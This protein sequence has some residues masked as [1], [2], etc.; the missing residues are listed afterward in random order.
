[1]A[2]RVS[3]VL[4][5]VLCA[6]L[7]L[8]GILAPASAASRN[9]IIGLPQVWS[10]SP[11]PV[12]SLVNRLVFGSEAQGG[13]RPGDSLRVKEAPTQRTVFD[14]EIPNDPAYEVPKFRIRR[15]QAKIERFK[16]DV[17]QRA[18]ASA[19]SAQ[20]GSQLLLPQF[21]TEISKTVLPT[22]SDGRADI[23]LFGSALFDDPRREGFSMR[24][25]AWPSDG[26][27]LADSLKSP[28]STLGKRLDGAR[29]SFCTSETAAD[30]LSDVQRERVERMWT[31]FLSEQGAQLTNFS[32][33]TIPCLENF[34]QGR[35]DATRSFAINRAEQPIM[36]RFKPKGPPPPIDPNPPPV[37]PPPAPRTSD[38]PS[39]LQPNVPLATAAP[40]SLKGPLKLGIRWPCAQADVDLYARA[41][42]SAPFAFFGLPQTPEA[43]YPRD[44]RTSPDREGKFEIIEFKQD[45][46]LAQVEAYINLY[47]GSC[48]ESVKG[49]VRAQF[50]DGKPYEMPFKIEAKTGNRGRLQDGTFSPPYW[51]KV[52]IR[53][54]LKLGARAQASGRDG[55]G[56]AR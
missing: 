18:S 24:E 8:G 26:L 9:V 21:L 50:G 23:L 46:N 13:L 32:G 54:L 5:A 36:Y 16:A 55:V 42:T 37:S 52:D 35:G 7:G 56:G 38:A 48:P 15:F 53:Q 10:G 49:V 34:I 41:S 29:V 6:F 39:W 19:G 25:G 27:L 51:T 17:R 12:L 14:L 22:L 43:I 31:L 20:K 40:S 4:G 44:F 28:Y 3:S 33:D 45:V 2:K 30:W 47:E 1:M 11:D